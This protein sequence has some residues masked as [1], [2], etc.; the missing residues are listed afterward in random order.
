MILSKHDINKYIDQYEKFVNSIKEI[1]NSYW[2][3][4][5][6]NTYQ[7]TNIPFNRLNGILI[8]YSDTRSI[9]DLK[10]KLDENK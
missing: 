4:G 9:T 5:K 6:N 3:S 8:L 1:M 7:N 10:N 2:F